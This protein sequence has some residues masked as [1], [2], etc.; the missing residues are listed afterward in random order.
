MKCNDLDITPCVMSVIRCRV[1]LPKERV[2]R[3]VILGIHDPPLT[4]RNNEEKYD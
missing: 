3:G 1:L 4:R 2:G